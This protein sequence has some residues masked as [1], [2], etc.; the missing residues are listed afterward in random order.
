M[1][2]PRP[3]NPDVKPKVDVH[4]RTTKVNFAVM[5][6]VIFFLLVAFIAVALYQGNPEKTRNEQHQKTE[7][8]P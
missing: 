7:S 3:Q 4:R 8:R 6:G 1:D 2:E 5:G